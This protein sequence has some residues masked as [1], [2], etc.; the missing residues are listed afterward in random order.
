VATS[1]YG[2]PYVQGSDL[3]SAYPT[4]SS[5]LATRVDEV[6]Y[7][8]NGL[9]AQTGTS[10]TLV[11]GDAGKTITLSNAAA[12]AVTLPQD[13][14]ATLPTGAV[15]TFYNLGAG[16]VTISQGT[17]ATL[18]GGSITLAQYEV[19]SV[20]KLSANTYGKADSGSAGFELVTARTLSAVAAENLNNVFTSANAVYEIFG[21]ITMS[22]TDRPKIRL[23][24][25]G[26][27]ATGASDYTF[28]Y[29]D[30]VST[31]AS[32]TS[33]NTSFWMPFNN[34]SNGIMTFRLHLINPATAVFTQLVGSVGFDP[35]PRVRM[36]SGRHQQNIAYDGFSVSPETGGTM[37][38]N[39]Y[40]YKL[41]TS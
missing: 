28:Q 8:R 23:R 24:V 27:D 25:G 13:S 36:G 15:V 16:T 32:A 40:V 34:T 10:Y 6:S 41:A 7:K 14:V 18:Q 29:V 19:T 37:T 38:G 35:T 33:G 4:A 26:V 39:V 31:T 9:N 2:T 11:V 30:G 1:T 21:S 20:I 17:G 12:V 22:G 3:V 5:N